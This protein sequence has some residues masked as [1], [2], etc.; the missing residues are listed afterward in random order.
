MAPGEGEEEG[1][2]LRARAHLRGGSPGQQDL[3]GRIGSDHLVADEDA[4]V[5]LASVRQS[6]GDTDPVPRHRNSAGQG[7]EGPASVDLN[8]VGAG[9]ANLG[10]PGLLPGRFL[11]RE[12]VHPHPRAGI[13]IEGFNEVTFP[14]YL[15]LKGAARSHQDPER[16]APQD[17]WFVVRHVSAVRCNATLVAD[18]KPLS[19][20]PVRPAALLVGPLH[21]LG[22]KGAAIDPHLVDQAGEA[23]ALVANEQSALWI[24]GGFQVPGSDQLAVYV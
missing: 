18:Y 16:F 24:D 2:V 22:G 14:S 9:F 3:L 21:L 15:H 1:G 11:F 20:D 10:L 5:F 8:L 7:V 19:L 4:H 23:P 17:R 13:G 12:N 6:I